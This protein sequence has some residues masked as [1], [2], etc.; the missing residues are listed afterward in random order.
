MADSGVASPTNEMD[1]FPTLDERARSST[2]Q[3]AKSGRVSPTHSASGSLIR[4]SIVKLQGEKKAKK[5]KF[6]RNGDRYFRGMV[7]AVSPEKFRRFESLLAELTESPLG[8]RTV[9]P[10]GVRHIFSIDGMKKITDIDDLEE[11]EHYVCASTAMFKKIDYPKSLTPV[12][13]TNAM[14]LK[15]AIDEKGSAVKFQV[16]ENKD[17]I[18]PKLI[19][20]IRNGSKPRKAVRMLL[21]KKTAH[22]F[23]QV[24]NDMT[25]AIKLD[26][27]AV[28]KIFTLDGR[29]VGIYYFT[30]YI[31]PT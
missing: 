20:V 11:D 26:S 17:F 27:G 21:N 24:M 30:F 25:E 18:Y 16:D 23:A 1:H 29:Q 7:Y 3:M 28:R 2:R 15:D 5:V 13:N 6:Y 9:L 8:D 12:W 4:A 14:P 22:S 19:T 31:S 10:N